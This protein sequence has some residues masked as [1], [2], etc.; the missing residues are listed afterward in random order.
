[1]K[2]SR[3]LVIFAVALCAVVV[4]GEMYA[5]LPGSYGYGSSAELEDGT[6]G[7]SVENRGSDEFDAVLLDNGDY[8]AVDTV[9]VYYDPDYA[10]AVNEDAAVEVGAQ[11]MF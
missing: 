5:Y 10:S 3:L 7:F 2:G 8:A 6:I 1:M 11:R 4:V 9:Y